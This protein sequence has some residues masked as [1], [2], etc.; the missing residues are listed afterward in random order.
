MTAQATHWKR[1]EHPVAFWLG[2]LA[3]TVGVAMHLPMYY[4]TRGMHYVMA[5][6]HPDAEMLAGMALIAIGLPS[7]LYGLVP[8]RSGEV[9]KLAAGIRIQSLDDAR[10]RWRH[11][12]ML[13]AL[14]IA[15]L[16]D[17]MKPAALS[18]AAPGM[19]REYGLKA[20]INPHGGL[21]AA[22]LPLCGIGG[23]VIGS[24]LWG[25]LADR[26]GRR[27]SI[28]Y[29]GLLFVAT[30]ICG[31]MP[32][33]TWNLTMCFFMGIGAGG[34]LPI[35]FTL[36]A[37][38]VP[39]RHRGWLMVLIGGG[40]ADV[41]Y[42]LT[43]WL[44]G[45]LTPEYSWRILWLIGLPTGLLF[46]AL[47]RW[48]PESPRFLIATGQQAEA[49]RIMSHFGATV[50]DEPAPAPTRA[51]RPGFLQGLFGRP[52]VG[53]SVAVIVLAA[54]T[55]LVTYGFQLWIPT[56]LEHLGFTSVNSDYVVRNATLL[57]LPLSVV[58]TACYGLWS[59]KRTILIACGALALSLIGFIATGNSVAH[60]HMLLTALL[61][62]PLSGTALVAALTMVYA[63]ETYPT[64]VRSRGTGLIAAA[65]KAGGVAIIAMA[66]AATSTPSIT[67]TAIAG[68]VPFVLGTVVFTQTGRETRN[69]RLEEM[70]AALELSRTGK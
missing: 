64:V 8:R 29:A 23:T 20:A 26:I 44:A 41:G 70:S 58:L 59:S 60:N 10:L 46:I 68:V 62:V 34:M 33:F 27:S 12:A 48:I 32:N 42:V 61:I 53:R 30:S 28:I 39:A 18:F 40:V 15:I 17:V 63:S 2:T 19:T 56:N 13:L 14:S 4:S 25:A 11:V 3:C 22:L 9:G 37:E 50:I 55:G 51:G 66:V 38:T 43:S 24:W 52:L 69:R 5:G 7:A 6:M 21:P 31:A 35:A 36:I 47:N 1:F 45:G 65:T 67:T 54:G 16:I 57:G 49:E